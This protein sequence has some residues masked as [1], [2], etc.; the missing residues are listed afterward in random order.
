MSKIL[1]YIITIADPEMVEDY[2]NIHPELVLEDI[3][4]GSLRCSIRKKVIAEKGSGLS[5]PPE[6]AE[7]DTPTL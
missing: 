4:H 5:N 3:V 1:E 2:K 6:D 7:W